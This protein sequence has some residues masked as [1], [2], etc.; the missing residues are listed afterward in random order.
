M[1]KLSPYLLFD[2]TCE[3]AM[4]FYHARLGGELALTKVSESPLKNQMPP[5]LQDR[6]LNA[7]LTAG[8]FD[9]SASDWML[10]NRSPAVGNTVCLYFSGGTRAELGEVFDGLS[11][12]ADVTDPLS[13][14]PFGAYGAL[15]D[16]FGVRW[17]F[18]AD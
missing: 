11:D 12:G 13:D 8:G 10:A 5:H 9:I 2:G 6:V 17:M 15:N 16:K 18:H 14:M 7:H 1:L 3:Q 4:Q